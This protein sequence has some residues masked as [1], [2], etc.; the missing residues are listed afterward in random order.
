MADL[1]PGEISS[2]RMGLYK[3]WAL[4]ALVP[5][6][7]CDPDLV[8]QDYLMW[9][10]DRIAKPEAR[11]KQRAAI[12][13]AG[14]KPVGTGKNLVYQGVTLAPPEGTRIGPDEARAVLVSLYAAGLITAEEALRNPPG[15]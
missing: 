1:R 8:R 4:G 11:S 5:G 3:D 6:G 9:C 2:K 13:A 7:S 10:S 14:G 15:G 12:V